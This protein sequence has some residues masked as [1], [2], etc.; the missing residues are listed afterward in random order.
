[1]KGK[2]S[3]SKSLRLTCESAEYFLDKEHRDRLN[4]ESAHERTLR[5]L[6]KPARKRKHRRWLKIALFALLMTLLLTPFGRL[7]A[8]G[9]PQTIMDGAE[10]G[11]HPA[12]VDYRMGLFYLVREEWELAITRFDEAIRLLPEYA[13]AF[14]ARGYCYEA[15][16]DIEQA[17]SDY[18]QAITLEPTYGPTYK[19]LA[20]LYYT[21]GN[22]VL[23]LE[24]YRMYVSLT[25]EA[26]DRVAVERVAE[27]EAVR[28]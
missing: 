19:L 5:L 16:S 21:Q 28:S 26:P 14:E 2:D 8:Q 22:H 27:L 25:G 18:Q 13:A 1:M 11:Y 9:G 12:L 23:A 3:D 24:N 17:E 4:A 20:D 15:L 7:Q 6:P 10:D